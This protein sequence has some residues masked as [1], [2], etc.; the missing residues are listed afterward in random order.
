MSAEVEAPRVYED[1]QTRRRQNGVAETIP[2]KRWLLPVS[3][4]LTAVV[5][6]GAGFAVSHFAV[7]SAGKFFCTN[8]SINAVYYSR[9]PVY[10]HCIYHYAAF[11]ILCFLKCLIQNA[12]HVVA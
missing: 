1:L 2:H 5:C 7:P 3:I 8:T 12:I 9:T 4:A 10:V 11:I 6:F